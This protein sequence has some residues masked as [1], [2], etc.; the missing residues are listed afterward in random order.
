MTVRAVGYARFSSD[1]Q[2]ETSIEIGEYAAG[3]G[4]ELIDK[5]HGFRN[6]RRYDYRSASVGT[7]TGSGETKAVPVRCHLG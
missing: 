7:A 3:H 6:Q 2:S 5:L 1:A 4:F